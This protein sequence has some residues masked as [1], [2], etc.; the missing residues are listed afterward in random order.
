MDG[1]SSLMSNMMNLH[2]CLLRIPINQ[3]ITVSVFL[4]WFKPIASRMF[5]LASRMYLK[6]PLLIRPNSFFARFMS[7]TV[8]LLSKFS[9]WSLW[10]LWVVKLLF[11]PFIFNR[12]VSLYFLSWLASLFFNWFLWT[13]FYN[14]E[15]LIKS[16]NIRY[17]NS[18][19]LGATVGLWTLDAGCWTLILR[20]VLILCS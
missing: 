13:N 5:L 20:T 3:P 11:S 19:T 8:G 17:R 9:L 4:H 15:A 1:W 10:Y 14:L 12:L 6:L 2:K 16:C 7:L 18:W